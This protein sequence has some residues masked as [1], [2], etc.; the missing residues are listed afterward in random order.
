MMWW[1]AAACFVVA[2]FLF[3]FRA[4]H[5][6]PLSLVS[7]AGPAVHTWVDVELRAVEQHVAVNI[8]NPN[9]SWVHNRGP[10]HQSTF[11]PWSGVLLDEL[12]CIPGVVLAHVA[13]TKMLGLSEQFR[14]GS[15]GRHCGIGVDGVSCVCHSGP[16]PFSAVQ[17]CGPDLSQTVRTWISLRKNRMVDDKKDQLQNPRNGGSG[18]RRERSGGRRDSGW[19]NRGRGSVRKSTSSSSS[20][21]PALLGGNVGRNSTR[22]RKRRNCWRSMIRSI[23]SGKRRPRRRRGHWNCKS[24]QRCC[25]G[26][27][28]TV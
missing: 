22:S 7:G 25:Q 28:R 18:A 4:C 20:S 8:N 19:R 2:A 10:Q 12:G 6:V 21:S 3:F 9:R 26:Y 13:R 1:L 23:S 16:G 5:P 24:Q 14:G 27:E 11:F 15:S 17:P